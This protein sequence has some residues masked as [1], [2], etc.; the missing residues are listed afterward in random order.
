MTE[1][2]LN[3]PL[4]VLVTFA[5]AGVILNLTPGADVMFAIASG[6]AGGPRTGAAAGL[7][8]GAGG[9][10]HVALA[11]AGLSALIAA[12]PLALDA[13]RYAGAAYLLWLAV[14]S[15]RAGPPE[16]GTARRLAPARAFRQGFLT[17]A[18]NPKVILFILAFLPQFTD[19]SRGPVWQQ[20]VLL[21]AIFAV[22]GTAIT[23]GYGAGAGW[24]GAALSRRL[25]LLNKLAA[26]VFGGLALRMVAGR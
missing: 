4:A 6:L 17:N 20:I 2:L 3:M 12:A 25:G 15:W 11:A 16:P 26:L 21:G 7:G 22:T 18:L 14:K 8:V 19:P 23:A 24:L 10:L 9:A 13:I 5:L 1:T